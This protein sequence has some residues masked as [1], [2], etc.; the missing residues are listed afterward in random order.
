MK[1]RASWRFSYTMSVNELIEYLKKMHRSEPLSESGTYMLYREVYLQAE[2][3]GLIQLPLSM[4][5]GYVHI[6]P[7]FQLCIIDGR[8]R[9]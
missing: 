5:K 9:E 4:H 8:V 2:E 3:Q 1:T 7:W 6:V